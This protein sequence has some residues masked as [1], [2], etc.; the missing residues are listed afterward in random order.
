MS[1]DWDAQAAEEFHRDRD[2]VIPPPTP[3][4]DSMLYGIIGD[5]AY[6]A[7]NGREVSPVAVALAAMSWLS[8]EVGPD[9]YLPIGDIKHHANLYT[10]HIGRSARGGKGE[11][12][13][14]VKRIRKNLQIDGIQSS[15]SGQMHSG[16][17]S[18]R[19]GLIGAVHDGYKLN[20]EECPPVADKRLWIVESEFA[21]VLV[22]GKREGN[23]LL[24]AL[25]DV[26]DGGSIQPLTK[27][28]GLWATHPHISIHGNVT[29]GEFIA[30][31]DVREVS[32]GTFNRFL[33]IW[34]ERT[35]LVP[36][37]APTDRVVVDSLADRIKVILEWAIG[38]YPTVRSSRSASIAP[39][40]A[41]L[42]VSLYPELK[43]PHPAGDWIAGMLERQA[44]ICLRIALL[45]AILDRSLTIREEHIR[46]G[47][48][49]VRYGAQTVAYVFDGLAKDDRNEEQEHRVLSFLALQP[50][51]EADRWTITR[52]CFRNRLS[53]KNLDKVLGPLVEDGKLARREEQPKAGGRKRIVY[54][55]AGAKNA[56]NAENLQTQG[57]P[58]VEGRAKNGE[59]CPADDVVS[60]QTSRASQ[61][62]RAAQR[63]VIIDSSLSPQTSPGTKEK[64]VYSGAI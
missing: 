46:V 45:H 8:A 10:L 32:G 7:S 20:G 38:G 61:A 37:P 27:G 4:M 57:V 29:P 58:P 52:D 15:I 13:G 16:G 22:Q 12:L 14:L 40:A 41:K 39:S 59:V 9:I 11:S 54:A 55:L 33:M 56:K 50:K 1:E 51:T 62:L 31:L 30:R 47:Y 26:W 2:G 21:N 42:W 64:A 44:P 36:F 25:R 23:T 63:F 3:D 28:K 60:A 43:R 34:A 49:W 19:E 17:L 5:I 24:P 18:S 35:C 53:G 48:A 6:A